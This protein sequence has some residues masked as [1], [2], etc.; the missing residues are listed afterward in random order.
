VASVS[1]IFVRIIEDEIYDKDRAERAKTKHDE[2]L[3]RLGKGKTHYV[4]VEGGQRSSPY[5]VVLYERK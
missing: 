2:M 1:D 5:R 4:K 3:A